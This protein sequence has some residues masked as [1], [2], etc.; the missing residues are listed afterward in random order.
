VRRDRD[1]GSG[2]SGLGL[3]L[4]ISNE[5]VRA[6]GGG[7]VVDTD[8]ETGTRFTITLPRNECGVRL[9]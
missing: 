1:R 4:F 8:P 3:G 7:I 5:I 2:I 9:G 6:H